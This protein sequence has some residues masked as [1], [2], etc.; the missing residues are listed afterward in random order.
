MSSPEI[1]VVHGP[2]VQSV[3]SLLYQ[4]TLPSGMVLTN[5]YSFAEAPRDEGPQAGPIVITEDGRVL[6]LDSTHA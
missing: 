1:T 4:V 2:T 6:T 3:S 5:P